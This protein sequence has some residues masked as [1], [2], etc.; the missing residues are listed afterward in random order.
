LISDHPES[1]FF[2]ADHHLIYGEQGAELLVRAGVASE[3]VHVVGSEI[4]ERGYGR[5]LEVDRLAIESL[6]PGICGRKLVVVGTE[7]RPE[8][9][10]EI[11]AVLEELTPMQD[12]HVVL[13]LHPND[14]EEPFHHL[15]RQLDHRANATV[16]SRC[17]LHALLNVADLLICVRSN[18]IIEAAVMGTPTLVCDF[19]PGTARLNMVDE[20][21]AIG[22]WRREDVASMSRRC[23]FDEETISE[24]RKL[25][26]GGLARFNGPNDGKSC[27]RI[28]DFLLAW[29]RD[30]LNI[31][32]GA[33]TDILDA[34]RN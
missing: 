1:K 7:N 20:G 34:N 14:P 6:I 11:Q 25:T 21:I 24:H 33:Q 12:L 4:S 8:Q 15:V 27:S 28:V 22:C 26:R 31:R 32:I 10:E 29:Q 16:I 13:K 2:P 5:C 23:L 30:V 9:M 3:T 19:N 17:D 18:I